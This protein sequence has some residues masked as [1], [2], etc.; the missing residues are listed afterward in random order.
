MYRVNIQASLPLF[1]VVDPKQ[2]IVSRQSGHTSPDS[3]HG[4]D[5]K[6]SPIPAFT[7]TSGIFQLVDGIV[8]PKPLIVADLQVPKVP[9]HGPISI[10]TSIATIFRNVPTRIAGTSSYRDC[11]D[12]PTLAD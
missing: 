3:T 7:T 12:Q 2:T 5:A 8:G 11:P 10:R 9:D 1:L 4:P 6:L